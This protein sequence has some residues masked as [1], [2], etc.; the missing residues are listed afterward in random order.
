MKRSEEEEKENEDDS[1]RET[2]MGKFHS[3]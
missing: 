1:V 2:E 3:I